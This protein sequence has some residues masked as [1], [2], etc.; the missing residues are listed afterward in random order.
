MQLG[1]YFDQTR[2]TGCFTCC[3][4]CKDWHDIAAGGAHWIRTSCREEGEF[5]QLFV[6]YLS[7]PCFHCLDPRCMAACPAGAIHKREDTG[8]VEVDQEKC[9][10]ESFCG[11]CQ[12][13][14]PY[15]SPQF[16]E[17]ENAK[18]QKC[19]LCLDRWL[20]GKKP[21]CVEACP[22]RALDAG[23]LEELKMKYGTRQEGAGFTYSL[24]MKPSVIFKPKL[25]PK[26]VP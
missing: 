3:I 6:A 23:P 19:N 16:G 4:A 25:K 14:C 1:F 5:P 20:E 22:M 11:V 7:Q 8:I 18:M 12:E 9:L 26:G 17:D 13:V 10:G 24:E 15:G 2:C 21:I